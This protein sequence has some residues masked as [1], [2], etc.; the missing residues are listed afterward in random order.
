MDSMPATLRI[1]GTIT[2]RQFEKIREL[3]EEHGVDWAAST[4]AEEEIELYSP[5]APWG[6]MEEIEEYL[7]RQNIPFDRHTEASSGWDGCIVFFRPYE[8]NRL[9]E[10]PANQDGEVVV[11]ASQL[12]EAIRK[13]SDREDLIQQ[14]HTLTGKYVPPLPPLKVV[15][16]AS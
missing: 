8:D 7:V 4:F 11:T 2:R 1:G 14:I 10:F 9:V 13:T 16:G 15:D 5:E 3:A 6:E 12:E